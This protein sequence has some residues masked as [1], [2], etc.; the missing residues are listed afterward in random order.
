MK[1]N[2]LTLKNL[3]KEKRLNLR[4]GRI[5]VI[6]RCEIFSYIK[7]YTYIRYILF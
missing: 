1:N 2:K 7:K 6:N 5:F 4:L 3:Q